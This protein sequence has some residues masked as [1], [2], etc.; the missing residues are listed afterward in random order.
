[1]ACGLVVV[2]CACVVVALSHV[3]VCTYAVALHLHDTGAC[4]PRLWDNVSVVS[5]GLRLL[6]ED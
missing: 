2:A 5:T 4:L 3:L 1:M 6:P